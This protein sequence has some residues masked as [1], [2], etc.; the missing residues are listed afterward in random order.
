MKVVFVNRFYAPDISATSQ[1]LTDL[2]EALVQRGVAV[3]VVTSAQR[4]DDARAR[5]PASE[6]LAG[7]QVHRLETTR[8][9]RRDL[10]RRA[11][12]YASFYFLAIRCLLKLLRSGD[13]VVLKTDPPLLSLLGPPLRMV[14]GCRVVNWLQD[15][16]PEAAQRL[17]VLPLPG[18]LSRLLVAMRDAS[19]RGADMNV[20]IGAKMFALLRDRA[21]PPDRLLH[22]PNWADGNAIRPVERGAALLR[23]TMQADGVFVVMYS[24]NLGRAHDVGAILGAVRELRAEPDVL[25]LFVGGGHGLESL[26]AATESEELRNV[27]FVPYQPR[28]SLGDAL[29]AADVHLVTLLPALEGLIVPSKLYGILAAGRPSIFI[30]DAQGEVATVLA[31]AECGASVA[32][33]DGAALATEIRRLR[34]DEPAWRRASLAA[35]R[36]FDES[37]GIDA[38]AARWCS[39]LGVRP[40]GQEPPAPIPEDQSGM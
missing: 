21:V 18:L 5:L 29:G 38:A 27:R 22:V 23:R 14:R 30:G 40:A 1:M 24:G 36:V 35:R 2:A 8:A 31:A 4:Y 20:V 17:G 25:F 11:L 37:G 26:R 9:G 33:G 19:L 12:D 28:E 16:F 10:S 7:V 34:D 3:H 39:M 32:C 15:I 13:V 6:L